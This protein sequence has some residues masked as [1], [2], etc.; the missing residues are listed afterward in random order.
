MVNSIDQW[1]ELYSQSHQNRINKTVHWIC[2][3]TITWTVIAMLWSINFSGLVWVN[4]GMM[5]ILIA[6]LFYIRLSISLMF[7]MLVFAVL[8][9]GLIFVHNRFVPIPLWQT[10]LVAF[11]VAWIGQFIGHKIEGKKPSFFQDIQFLFIGP[12]WLL[13]FIYKRLGIPL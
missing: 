9:I 8:C 6:V 13:S 12:A 1:L 10:S 3:P 5:F 7:G 11:I 4:L 2:V